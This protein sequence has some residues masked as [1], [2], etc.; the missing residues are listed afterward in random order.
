M[1]NFLF[2]FFFQQ[3]KMINEAAFEFRLRK[4]NHEKMAMFEI[5]TDEFS[6]KEDIRKKLLALSDP[7]KFI[8]NRVETD[9][10]PALAYYLNNDK[11][12]SKLY[13]NKVILSIVD[14]F[15]FKE[16]YDDITSLLIIKNTQAESNRI[17]LRN[18][19][20]GILSYTVECMLPNLWI[21]G[22]PSIYMNNK[23]MM[24]L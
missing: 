19:E 12:S 21:G 2:N 22:S 17:K 24:K 15:V 10:V 6:N 5:E 18:H 9:I 1:G 13:T 14:Y 16:K 3:P 4:N 8:L 23:T 7:D 20:N 11:S